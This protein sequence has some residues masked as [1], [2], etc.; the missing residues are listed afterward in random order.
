MS[1]MAAMWFYCLEDDSYTRLA[2]TPKKFSL[3]LNYLLKVFY[4]YIKAKPQPSI[5]GQ[6]DNNYYILT[7]ISKLV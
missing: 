1:T 2:Q 3:N 4:L 7:T 5:K 6:F